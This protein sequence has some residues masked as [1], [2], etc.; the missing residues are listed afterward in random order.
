MDAWFIFILASL[1]PCL[2]HTYF[3]IWTNYRASLPGLVLLLG[4]YT[5]SSSYAAFKSALA[6]FIFSFLSYR[7]A[8]KSWYYHCCAIVLSCLWNV[9]IIIEEPFKFRRQ[10]RRVKMLSINFSLLSAFP[11]RAASR[12]RSISNQTCVQYEHPRLGQNLTCRNNM[13]YVP[14]TSPWVHYPK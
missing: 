2:K 5:K 8:C 4:I 11:G 12:V 3:M 10:T 9:R 14:S 7:S 1:A 6:C 13:K